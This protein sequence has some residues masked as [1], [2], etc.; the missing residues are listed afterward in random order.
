MYIRFSAFDELLCVSKSFCVF[1][2]A[3]EDMSHAHWALDPLGNGTTLVSDEFA[4]L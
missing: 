2:T 4:E 3:A 1:V